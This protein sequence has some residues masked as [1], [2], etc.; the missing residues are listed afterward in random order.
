MAIFVA[1]LWTYSIFPFLQSWLHTTNI[2]LQ[3]I[4][5]HIV[6]IFN[7]PF[8]TKLALYYR[9]PFVTIWGRVVDTWKPI[10]TKFTKY[11]RTFIHITISCSI[12]AMFVRLFSIGILII[13]L[14][15]LHLVFDIEI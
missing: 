9:Y 10:F 12:V 6:D 8:L 15:V 14:N 5:V 7:F 2:W 13:L 3:R 11:L 4:C 1:V